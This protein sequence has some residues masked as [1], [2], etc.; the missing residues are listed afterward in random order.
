MLLLGPSRYRMRKGWTLVRRE[1][2]DACIEDRRRF[3]REARFVEYSD[4]HDINRALNRMRKVCGYIRRCFQMITAVIVVGLMIVVAAVLFGSG[5]P[6]F[7]DVVAALYMG[8]SGGFVVAMLWNLSQ[9][10]DN[11]VSGNSPFSEDQADRL[12]SVAVIALSYF[13]LDALFSFAFI[14]NPFPE[15]GFGMVAND[16]IAEPTINLNFGMLAFSAIMYSLS[17]IF[18][19]AALLQQLSD[20]TV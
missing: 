7:G 11:V 20:E 1:N 2:G 14:A 19:Y 5:A 10:F 4:D 15:I 6:L 13:V 17:A 18:R 12:K 8:V 9:L 16:G 3:L